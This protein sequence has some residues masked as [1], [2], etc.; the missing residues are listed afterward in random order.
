MLKKLALLAAFASAVTQAA[1][2]WNKA[3]VQ[4]AA[5]R[6][7]ETKHDVQRWEDEGGNL[8]PAALTNKP[9]AVEAASSRARSAPA[10]VSS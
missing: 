9:L 6:K 7:R 5:R 2:Y 10:S 4:T 1:R 8:P 3:G